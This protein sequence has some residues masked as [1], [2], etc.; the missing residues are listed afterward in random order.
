MAE[1][2]GLDELEPIIK[3]ITVQ[4][5]NQIFHYNRLGQLEEYLEQ[6]PIDY[7]LQSKTVRNKKGKILVIGQSDVRKKDMRGIISSLAYS[8]ERFEL[9][10]NYEEIEQYSFKKLEYNDRYD[11]IMVGPVP[12]KVRGLEKESGIIEQIENNPDIYPPLIRILNLSG[13]LKITK[14]GFKQALKENII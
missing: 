8:T 13:E 3:D 5:Q 14:S 2:L 10:I 6:L 7:K 1:I 9:V 12:H 11:Y 4:I